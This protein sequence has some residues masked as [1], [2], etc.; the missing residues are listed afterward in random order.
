MA[1]VEVKE[2]RRAPRP[3]REGGHDAGACAGGYDPSRQPGTGEQA[4]SCTLCEAADCSAS[5]FRRDA[6]T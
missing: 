2:R 1:P 6:V 3:G 4:D 5:R